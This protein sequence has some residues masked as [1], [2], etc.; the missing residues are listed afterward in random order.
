MEQNGTLADRAVDTLESVVLTVKDKATVPLVTAVRAVVF[1]I[2][3]FVLA[4]VLL[5]LVVIGVVRVADVWLLGWA[6]RAHGHIRL[7]IAYCGLGILFTL[8][9]LWCWS[10]GVPKASTK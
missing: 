3:F 2:V 7:W 5:V 1:G 4:V 6:G 8:A 9:G 10:K